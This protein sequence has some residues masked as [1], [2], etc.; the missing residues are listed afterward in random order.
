MT[1]LQGRDPHHTLPGCQRGNHGLHTRG[2]GCLRA[3]H[4]IATRP[5]MLPQHHSRTHKEGRQIITCND[6]V[7]RAP[8]PPFVKDPVGGGHRFQKGH[9]S[10][11]PT[12]THVFI[13][14]GPSKVLNEPKCGS[15]AHIPTHVCKNFIPNSALESANRVLLSPS[16][17]DIVL[18]ASGLEGCRTSRLDTPEETATPPATLPRF[19]TRTGPNPSKAHG[20]HPPP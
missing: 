14:I 3:D 18:S 9:I 15:G 20:S 5:P 8:H 4:I 16:T 6:T 17:V 7:T 1:N 11:S 13:T 12:T 2:H 10:A 19:G